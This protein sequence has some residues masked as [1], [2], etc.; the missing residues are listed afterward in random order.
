MQVSHVEDSESDTEGGADDILPIATFEK[1]WASSRSLMRTS[2][3]TLLDIDGSGHSR[4]KDGKRIRL[5]NSGFS[6]AEDYAEAIDEGAANSTKD[7]AESEK[8]DVEAEAVGSKLKRK[9]PKIG[10][11]MAGK[12]NRGRRNRIVYVSPVK[13]R[14]LARFE[15]LFYW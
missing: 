4:K 13:M 2:R 1:R 5:H 10:F 8:E 12:R 15:H 3:E 7:F 14:V 9:K 11:Q 6:D